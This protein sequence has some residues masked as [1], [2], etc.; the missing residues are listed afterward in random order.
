MELVDN[1]PCAL[2]SQGES[3]GIRKGDI[4]IDRVLCSARV[5]VG[6]LNVQGCRE[7]VRECAELGT[8]G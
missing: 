8:G 5:V 1:S 2:Y 3:W 6:D 4:C 7:T